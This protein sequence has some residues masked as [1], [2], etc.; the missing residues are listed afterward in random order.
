MYYYNQLYNHF[1]YSK[2][3]VVVAVL[4][5]IDVMRWWWWWLM[6][7]SSSTCV[8]CSIDVVGVVVAA[9]AAAANGLVLNHLTLV[10]FLVCFC[11]LVPL[12]V[13]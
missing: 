4:C 2:I 5:F 11:C 12:L 1:N 6:I 9:A 8:V 13:N 10:T 7:V 3:Y